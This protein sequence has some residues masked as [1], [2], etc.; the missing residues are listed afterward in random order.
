MVAALG[1]GSAGLTFAG[2]SLALNSAMSNALVRSRARCGPPPKAQKAE[3][4]FLLLRAAE[5]SRPRYS[6]R[7]SGSLSDQPSL[8]W[9]S[10]SHRRRSATNRRLQLESRKSRELTRK[11]QT[12]SAAAI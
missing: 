6:L 3:R 1:Y 10:T 8:L 11:E 9:P 4:L 7:L 5:G 12:R 2:L